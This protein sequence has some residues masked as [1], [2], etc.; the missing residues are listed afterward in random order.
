MSTETWV[1]VTSL[2]WSEA[3]QAT[4]SAMSSGWA[5]PSGSSGLSS[6]AGTGKCQRPIGVRRASGRCPWGWRPL[7]GAGC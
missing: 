5:M 7:Q 4:A 6:P 2:D 3:S 1:A